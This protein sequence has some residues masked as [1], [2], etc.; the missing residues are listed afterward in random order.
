MLKILR[1]TF[2]IYLSV[3]LFGCATFNQKDETPPEIT[4]IQNNVYI[5][6]NKDGIQDEL[7]LEIGI[8]EINYISYWR[9]EIFDSN[10]K[11]V[12]FLESDE[13][14]VDQQKK[15]VLPNKSISVPK[16]I[17]WDGT[18]MNGKIVPDGEY[19]FTFIAMDNK[20]N[21][22]K[23]NSNAGIVYVDTDNPE[24][25]TEVVDKIFSPN[26]DNSKDKLLIK[27]NIVKKVVGSVFKKKDDSVD[28]KKQVWYIDILD[29][30]D[31]LIKRYV[32]DKK[33]QQE[34]EWDGTD[35]KGN[36]VPD[37]TYKIKSYSTDLAGNYYE[38]TV[39]NIVKNTTVTPVKASVT[40]EA[41]SPNNDNIKDKIGFK[42][43]TPVSNGIE[44][45]NFKILDSRGEIVKDFSGEKN[46]PAEIEWDGKDNN[47]RIAK[48]GEYVGQ[49][50]VV[51]ENGNKPSNNTAVFVL[52][53]TKPN[54]DISLSSKIFSPDGNK[55]QDELIIDHKLSK[56]DTKWEGLFYDDKGN[57]VKNYEW[58]GQTSYRLI[59]E[60]K[61]NQDA[62]LKDGI[63]FYQVKCTDKAGNT[64]ISE[65]FE[66]KIYTGDIPLFITAALRSFSPNNDNIKD[67]QVF[68]I[69][70]N[71]PEGNK[72]ADWKLEI[73]DNKD[74]V[75]YSTSDKGDLPEKVDWNGK[76]NARTTVPD[77]SYKAMLYVNFVAGTESKSESKEFLVDT[78][79]PDFSVTK[80]LKY[81]S[82]DD[83]GINDKLTFNL[84]AKD[85]TGIDKWSI[86]IISPY[87][88]KIFREFVGIGEPE[89][90]IVWDG[91]SSEGE[92]VESVED[93]PVILYAE[94][95][96]G[97]SIEK[98]ADPIMIDILVIKL[99]DGRL[100]VRVSNIKFKPD[101]AVMTNDKKNI[102]VLDLLSNALKKYP[103]HN[104]RMEGFANRYAENLN[105]RIAKELSEDRA[106][107]VAREL[108]KRGIDKGRMTIV[109]RG[110]ED[111][112]IP[113]T[114]DMTKEEREEMARNRRVEFYLEQ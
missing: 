53:V 5:S 85:E 109:G 3:F 32:F 86:K 64:Y 21:L 112:I 30:K 100:K 96:V 67:E 4:F 25:K 90:N 2:L 97:N 56:E 39:S 102:E 14:L 50:G 105:E 46:P 45:W 49:L 74:K 99:D 54:A 110:F 66:S 23:K 6:P 8:K 55:K 9:F 28:E 92:L 62:L 36:L 82:P 41:F 78:T 98:K 47:G 70:S 59:W 65:K 15:L 72:V 58:Q 80:D 37:G 83:D 75:V 84:S 108:N 11:S 18:D 31:N 7:V 1:K 60:G 48:E 34:L 95:L 61:D 52:D 10:G 76:I 87:G 93:Y 94:D 19:T 27:V 111:P 38:E 113:L 114:K 88:S 13:K 81:F 79:P 63:Y 103:H 20:K 71:I 69:R 40:D 44:K 26:N 77:G 29:E 12:K 35:E 24:I 106:K 22:S 43:E 89:P 42:F 91:R 17:T 101:R 33:G 104:I 68:E 57:L 16:R 73:I 51:Y 107:T